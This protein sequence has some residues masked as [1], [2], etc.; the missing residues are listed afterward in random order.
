MP[1]PLT[2]VD[3]RHR[4]RRRRRLRLVRF[5]AVVACVLIAGS[6]RRGARPRWWTTGMAVR[7][8]RRRRQR[9]RRRRSHRSSGPLRLIEVATGRLATPVQDA[10]AAALG[11][12][13]IMLLGGLTAAD[14]SRT[15]IRIARASGDRAAGNLPTA[16]HDTAAVRLGRHVYLFGGGT[17]ANTQSA[18]ILRIPTSGAS[19]TV[20]GRLPAPSSDQSAAAI[21]DTAYIVGGYT[22]TQWLTRSSPGGPG[23]PRGSSPA[24]PFRFAT[25][26]SRPWTASL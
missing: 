15:D 11:A 3:R 26:R 7:P 18:A 5:G 16:L 21:D 4:R 23:R 19:A 25:R 10:A 17:G 12:D 24:C 8:Q 6:D 1:S 20:A 22:G 9:R 2:P 13:R 14:T